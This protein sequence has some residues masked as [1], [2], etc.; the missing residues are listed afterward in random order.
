MPI[1]AEIIGSGSLNNATIERQQTVEIRIRVQHGGLTGATL[2]FVAKT[3]TTVN[4]EDD[5]RA[6]INKT[7]AALGGIVIDPSSTNAI[8]IARMK[9]TGIETNLLPIG[10]LFWGIQVKNAD[11]EI[12]LP[13]LRGKIAVAPDIVRT[14]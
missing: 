12:I 2:R 4:D 13:E 5:S 9:I 11:D 8:L 14:L 7:S 6:L 10:E 3:A 1:T